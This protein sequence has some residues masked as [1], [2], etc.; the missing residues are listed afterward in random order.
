[1]MRSGDS[2]NYT[3]MQQIAR[4]LVLRSQ[5]GLWTAEPV[6]V[7]DYD[8]VN[9]RVDLILRNHPGSSIIRGVPIAG[10]TG[11]F[12]V[13]Q[14][15]RTAKDW[16]GA[17]P[18]PFAFPDMGLL[19]FTRT[20]ATRSWSTYHVNED[21]RIDP[22][23]PLIHGKMGGFFIPGG[24]LENDTAPTVMDPVA[25]NAQPDDLGP[26]DF[27]FVHKSGACI[28]FKDDGTVVI[29]GTKVYLGDKTGDVVDFKEVARKGD[30]VNVSLGTGNGTITGGS[31]KVYSG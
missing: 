18:K 11:T 12:R 5:E 31:S 20:D 23:S 17:D 10:G 21:V 25:T 30:S 16:L 1:M 3:A 29:K 24:W 28:L 19:M 22:T 7:Y 6:V 27:G 13:I 15:F 9:Q 26:D 8:F 2:P 4:R 14:P